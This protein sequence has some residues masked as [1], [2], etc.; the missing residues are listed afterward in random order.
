[1]WSE[2]YVTVVWFVRCRKR[3]RFSLQRA[4]E[5]VSDT[6][7]F[8]CKDTTQFLLPRCSCSLRVCTVLGLVLRW[9]NRLLAAC[10]V[11]F[12]S[13]CSPCYFMT[14]I[15]L[16]LIQ[17]NFALHKATCR[18]LCVPCVLLQTRHVYVTWFCLEYAQHPPCPHL[19]REL[20][21]QWELL[22]IIFGTSILET[23][24]NTDACFCQFWRPTFHT[25]F[26]HMVRIIFPVLLLTCR[27]KVQK[28]SPGVIKVF[29][30][31]I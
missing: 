21:S 17:S 3:R 23:E 2:C 11:P 15:I 12:V 25:T 31:S 28:Q 13:L 26:A 18:P 27:I 29:W 16:A 20:S 7:N 24:T 14:L 9:L 30:T 10:W 1:M 4:R 22:C 5:L 8:A 6:Y 19:L